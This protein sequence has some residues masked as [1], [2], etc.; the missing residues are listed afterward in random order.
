[1]SV[2]ADP[3]SFGNNLFYNKAGKV[4]WW[5]AV[6]AI[7]A[8]FT[9]FKILYPYAGFI[10]GDSYAYLQ[11][12]YFNYDI[13]TYP[14]GYSKFLRL[15]SVFSRS[16]TALVAFQ[17]LSIQV[18]AL[19][20][21][22]TLFSLYT[23]GR[24]TKW[25]LF[26]LVVFN[27]AFLYLSNY[28]SSDALFLSVSLIWFTLLLHLLRRP[29]VRLMIWQP[30]VLLLAF[31]IRY[32]ALYY[33][34]VAAVALLLTRQPVKIKWMGIT[35]TFLVVAGFMFFTGG[36]Y[37]ELTGTWQFTPFS[38]W[39]IANNAL[40]AYRYAT[41]R[42]V[43][44]VPARFRSL[45]RMVRNYFDTSRDLRTHPS[46]MVI[47]GTMYMWDPRSPLQQYMIQRFKGSSAGSLQQWA[48]MAPLYAAYGSYLVRSYPAA[49]FNYYL[50]PNALKYYAPPGEFLDTYNMGRDTVSRI[51]REWFGY[52]TNKVKSPFNDFTVKTLDFLPILAGAAN[53]VFM[54][55]W[56][57]VWLLKGIGRRSLLSRI[58]WL[59]LTLWIVNFGFSV[60]AAPIT[61]RYQLFAILV[62]TSFSVLLTDHIYKI[63]FSH[64]KINLI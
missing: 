48:S 29:T 59:V 36:K 46:E 37:K 60:L 11:S 54:F 57:F 5:V 12:A 44:Q 53:I 34:V 26:I 33:P 52:K 6:M 3:G 7:P 62:L 10:N 56:L 38:G 23:P 22:F 50:W 1:M 30:G 55:G 42:P 45:D 63:A 14:I 58:A 25:L 32:N 39:Q 51:A 17:Y 31:M 15:F 28:V 13:S 18:S 21:I 47:A 41:P 8:Q 64:S 49:Y 16:D 19:W 35:A 43:G 20:F 9:V 27:P 24:I 61:L 4:F 40:Y 2:V